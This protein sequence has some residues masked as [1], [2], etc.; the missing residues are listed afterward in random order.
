M[1]NEMG[2]VMTFAEILTL[3]VTGGAVG[4]VAWFASWFLEGFAFWDKLPSKLKSLIILVLA[5]LVGILATWL[6]SL[7]PEQL[8]PYLPYISMVIMTVVAWLGTQVAHRADSQA[9]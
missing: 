2:N 5:I 7:P 3:L 4:A 9:K 8:A 1:E 6:L